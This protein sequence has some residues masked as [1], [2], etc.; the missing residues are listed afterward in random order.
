MERRFRV[1]VWLMLSLMFS[2]PVFAGTEYTIPIGND[3]DSPYVTPNPP[4]AMSP[5]RGWCWGQIGKRGIFTV[6]C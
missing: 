2:A 3:I 6:C 5:E 1:V 4:P